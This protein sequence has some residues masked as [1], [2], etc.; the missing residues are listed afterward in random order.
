MRW[1]VVPQ[2]PLRRLD[3]KVSQDRQDAFPRRDTRQI[4]NEKPQLWTRAKGS[5]ETPTKGGGRGKRNEKVVSPGRL[6]S[7]EGRMGCTRR[8]ASPLT[9]HNSHCLT[10][11]EVCSLFSNHG[12]FSFDM[13]VLRCGRPHTHSRLLSPSPLPRV[14]PSAKLGPLR[15]S[16]SRARNAV[17]RRC[18]FLVSGAGTEASGPR[19]LLCRKGG[20]GRDCSS[21]RSPHKL[22][23]QYNSLNQERMDKVLLESH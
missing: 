20:S 16:V 14:T 8:E 13:G 21:S 7:D 6:P 19:Q 11:L 4:L 10:G 18:L 1:F 2:L 12:P 23:S 15:T 9:P 17:P 22:L 3:S 5:E